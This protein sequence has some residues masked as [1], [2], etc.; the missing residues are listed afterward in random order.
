MNCCSHA[1][2]IHACSVRMERNQHLHKQVHA[3][4]QLPQQPRPHIAPQNACSN[5]QSD[6]G[7]NGT[8]SSA[9]AAPNARTCSRRSRGRRAAR[10]GKSCKYTHDCGNNS[11]PLR[12]ALVC[13]VALR[14]AT[15]LA[16]RSTC[17]HSLLDARL[18][19][20]RLTHGR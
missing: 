7:S 16:L 4:T 5:S 9:S 17:V 10:S 6:N 11:Q 19:T 14:I 12:P 13:H 1:H 2:K 8:R 20:N 18:A 15:D 3:H